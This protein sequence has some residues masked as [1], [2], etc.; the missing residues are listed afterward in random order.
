MATE[1]RPTNRGG[2]VVSATVTSKGQITI[3]IDVRVA[4]GLRAGVRVAFVPTPNGTYELVPETR[5]IKSL[6]G[7]VGWSG[8]PIGLAEMN[9]AIAGNVVEGKQQ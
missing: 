2:N 5:T 8:S 1:K 7:I 6:K 4:M 9:E 3:P